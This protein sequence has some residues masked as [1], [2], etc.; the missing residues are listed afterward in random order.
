MKVGILHLSDIH[1]ENAEDWICKKGEKIA[2]AVL[3][4]WEQLHTIF[5]VISGDVANKGYAEQYSVANDL[6]VRIRDYLQQQSNAKV[7]FIVAPGNHDCDFSEG[8]FD[9]KARKAFIDT[10]VRNPS[11]IERGDSIYEGCLSVQENFF[12]LH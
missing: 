8:K 12:Q 1:I 11:D 4:T 10:V 2:Q 3:G 7:F 6:F 9:V 5:I